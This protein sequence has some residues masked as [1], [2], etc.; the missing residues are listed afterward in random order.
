MFLQSV[1][2]LLFCCWV[3]CGQN[4]LLEVFCE[5]TLSAVHSYQRWDCQGFCLGELA[6]AKGSPQSRSG[7]LEKI[8]ISSRLQTKSERLFIEGLNAENLE[9]F[10]EV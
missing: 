6:I 7:E 10:K 2:F 3:V 5:Q 9:A 1:L 8:F 4:D